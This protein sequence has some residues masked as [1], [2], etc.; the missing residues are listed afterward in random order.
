MIHQLYKL[1]PTN[2]IA[3]DELLAST[4][5]AAIYSAE[6][7]RQFLARFENESED[8][9]LKA[10]AMYAQPIINKRALDLQTT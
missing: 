10:L 4:E 8:L 2:Y 6:E 7:H 1:W 5:Y 9:R 3:C